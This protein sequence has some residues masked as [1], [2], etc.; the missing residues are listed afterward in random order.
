MSGLTSGLN[1]NLVKTELDKVFFNKFNE[2]PGPQI[3]DV[4]DEGI[5]HQDAAVNAAV[6]TELMNDGGE[7]TQR[8]SDQQALAQATPVSGQKRTFTVESY[9]Q[10]LPITK[11]FMDDE[12]FDAVKRQVIAHAQKGRFTDRKAGFSLYRGAFTTTTTNDGA[13]LCS[14]SHTNLN[15]DTVDNLLTAALS[16]DSLESAIT[17][18]LEQKDQSGDIVGYEAKTLLVPPGLFKEAVEITD[19]KLEANTADNQLNVYSSKYGI[20]VVQSQYIGAA[21]GGSDSAW[22]LLS[23]DHNVFRW[24]RQAIE[25]Y[26]VPFEYSPELIAYYKSEY[27]NV[28]GATSYVGLVGSTGVA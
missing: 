13:A 17:T 24:E 28:Y 22:F 1:P 20:R 18:L 9:G 10:A 4:T 11:H 7:W 27:R 19:S 26:F 15:G 8:T 12:M 3:A 5:F 2:K 21:A 14:N 16:P 23:D 25:T 6:I